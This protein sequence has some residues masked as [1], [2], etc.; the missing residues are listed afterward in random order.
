M[1]KVLFS[2]P[3][4]KR[5]QAHWSLVRAI[6]APAAL[7]LIRSMRMASTDP[8]LCFSIHPKQLRHPVSIRSHT[9]DLDIFCQ[10]FVEQEYACLKN[11][12]SP[13]LIIDCGANVGFSSAYFLSTFPESRVIA[14][15]PDLS[16]YH[17]AKCNLSPYGDRAQILNVGIWSRCAGLGLRKDRYRDGR[18]S[19]R[20][21]EE[22]DPSEPGSI[23]GVDIPYLLSVSGQDR[24]S[25]LKMDVEGA[26]SKVFAPEANPGAWL[27]LVDAIVIELHDDSV[28][29]PC[30]EIFYEAVKDCGFEFSVSGELT[31]CLP[32]RS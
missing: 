10:I 19:S 13:G 16:N 26:E 17:A 8:D 1:P 27:H 11:T 5:L 12:L 9:S 28:F 4:R 14:V 24:I 7:Q 32:P 29:G 15:E 23:R 6:G 20:Q 31:V 22:I 30:S 25:L 2:P 18:Q 21:V 3:S